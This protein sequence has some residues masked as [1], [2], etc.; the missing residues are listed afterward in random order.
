MERYAELMHL[1]KPA[2]LTPIATAFVM[3][4]DVEGGKLMAPHFGKIYAA[5]H[6]PFQ[7]FQTEAEAR[8]W[9]QRRLDLSA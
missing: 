8:A 4:P 3:G 5:I 9:A 7:V 6:R 2:E 1:P